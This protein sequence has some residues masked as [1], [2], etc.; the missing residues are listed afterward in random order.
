MQNPFDS[1][2]PTTSDYNEEDILMAIRQRVS[3]MLDTQPELL[4]SY[5]YRLDVLEMD[6]KR[7]LAFSHKGDIV[8]DFA[9]LIWKRQKLRMHYKAKYKQDPIEGWEF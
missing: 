8:N 3:D 6:L 7:V 9:D 1:I 5:L 4:M 2:L